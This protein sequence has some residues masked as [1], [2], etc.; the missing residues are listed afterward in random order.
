[1]A[2]TPLKPLLALFCALMPCAS[3]AQDEAEA[4]EVVEVRPRLGLDENSYPRQF[5]Y[6]EI[7]AITP[8]FTRAECD[9]V[10]SPTPRT[11]QEAAQLIDRM[12]TF[13]MRSMDLSIASRLQATYFDGKRVEYQEGLAARTK[14]LA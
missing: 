2:R 6:E 3:W 5:T 10:L 13:M 11:P 9:L 4:P 1:M 14:A 7:L 12:A 8:L